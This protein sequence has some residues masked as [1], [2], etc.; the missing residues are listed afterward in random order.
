MPT[1]NVTAEL[2][3]AST[4]QIFS[5]LQTL[6]DPR[7]YLSR[8]HGAVKDLVIGRI[9]TLA[10]EGPV[11]ALHI[12]QAEADFM[13]TARQR[14][15]TPRPGKEKEDQQAAKTF[16]KAHTALWETVDFYVYKSD[17]R[18]HTAFATAS[19]QPVRPEPKILELAN[20]MPAGA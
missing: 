8:N 6:E 1:Y 15:N 7:G 19:K 20:L 17:H 2:N 13:E 9:R 14:S 16:Q 4:I 5:S 18:A 3:K 12:F 11:T 10:G